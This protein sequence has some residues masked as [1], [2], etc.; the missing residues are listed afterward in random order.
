MSLAAFSA[1]WLGFVASMASGQGGNKY[2]FP[3]NMSAAEN[4]V[5]TA[6][7]FKGVRCVDWVIDSPEGDMFP[8]FPEVGQICTV[9]TYR[10]DSHSY[11]VIAFNDRVDPLEVHTEGYGDI[12]RLPTAIV[13]YR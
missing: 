4:L 10:L 13:Q 8:D 9:H 6:N 5:S 2:D 12:D 11:G 3:S 7:L 1:T